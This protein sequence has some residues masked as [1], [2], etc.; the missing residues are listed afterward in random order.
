[1][2]VTRR[3]RCVCA[4]ARLERNADVCR[5]SSLASENGDYHV[6]TDKSTNP[7]FGRTP[8]WRSSG[9]PD[10]FACRSRVLYEGS[11]IHHAQMDTSR[12]YE[13]PGPH[14]AIDCSRRSR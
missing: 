9:T 4:P 12:L 8:Q 3:H 13:A 5:K 10:L 1:H 2:W 11:K 6:G 14:G 7:L